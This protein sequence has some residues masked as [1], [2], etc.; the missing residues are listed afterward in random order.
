MEVESISE[1][2]G[3]VAAAAAAATVEVTEAIVQPLF[4]DTIESVETEDTGNDDNDND[5]SDDVSDES[6]DDEDASSSSS[7]SVEQG[8]NSA[9]A[10][11]RQWIDE[12]DNIE[13]HYRH[14][15]D[16]RGYNFFRD[17]AG[18]TLMIQEFDL[19]GE[20]FFNINREIIM[21]QSDLFSLYDAVKTPEGV[22]ATIF[23]QK[24]FKNC[25]TD[26]LV[27]A[28]TILADDA[29]SD[30]SSDASSDVSSDASS[31]IS[32]EEEHVEQPSPLPPQMK[33][34]KGDSESVQNF[35]L[36]F[37]IV[38]MCLRAIG[39]MGQLA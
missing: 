23:G 9:P 38:L 32:S 34:E 39:L 1:V 8:L 28:L 4:A 11:M 33:S 19:K 12:I 7:A 29:S 26:L 22:S 24:L 25:S 13:Y 15:D 14:D 5:S 36:S 21:K 20:R 30:V 18:N 35:L 17:P 2:S 6:D 31:D 10:E 37:F 16:D 27:E 3:L